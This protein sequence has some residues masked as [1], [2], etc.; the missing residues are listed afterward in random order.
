MFF[1]SLLCSSLRFF[2]SPLGFFFLLEVSVLLLIKVNNYL[3][4]ICMCPSIWWMILIEIRII[5]KS[6]VNLFFS[7]IVRRIEKSLFLDQLINSKE[8]GFQ[9]FSAT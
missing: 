5:K 7:I 6:S 4:K 9:F 8:R 3:S 2:C 1:V